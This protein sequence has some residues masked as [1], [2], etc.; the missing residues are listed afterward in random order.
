MLHLNNITKDFPRHDG[1]IMESIRNVSLT[2]KPGEFLALVG[3]SGCGKTTLL[4]IIAGLVQPT[5]GTARH[6]GEM[7]QSTGKDR[8]MVFQHFA[9]FPW[10][11]VEDNIAFGPRLRNVPEEEVQKTVNHYLDITGL[12]QFC[13]QYPGTLSGGMQQRVAIAKT[14]ANDPEILLMDEPFGALDHQTRGQ[15]QEFL[16]KLCEDQP[17]TIVFVT[18]DLEEAIFLADRVIL[19][20]P[21]PSE[22]IEEFTIPFPRPR[23]HKLKLSEDFFKLKRDILMRWS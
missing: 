18:H 9:L 21:R 14:L 10:L 5:S 23:T 11:T 13:K 8:G 4:R 7:I 20:G 17:K 15:M 19:L 1:T 3:P 6:D 16:A 2:V 12:E 22:I